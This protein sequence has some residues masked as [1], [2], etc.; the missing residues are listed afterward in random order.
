MSVHVEN[1]YVGRAITTFVSI[2][3]HTVIR[4]VRAA[5]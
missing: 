1:L 2:Q 4:L 3:T 5:A